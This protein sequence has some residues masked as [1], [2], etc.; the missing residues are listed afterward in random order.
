MLNTYNA[1]RRLCQ[2]F[3]SKLKVVVVMSCREPDT[4]TFQSS[5]R[6]VSSSL[7]RHANLFHGSCRIVCQLR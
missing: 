3:E 5:C 6:S 7:H 1:P 2:L 4:W